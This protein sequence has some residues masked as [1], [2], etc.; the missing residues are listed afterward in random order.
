M[1]ASSNAQIASW[2]HLIGFLCIMAGLMALGFYAQHAAASEHGNQLASHGSAV[3]I[4]LVAG[5]MDWALLY[6][7]WAGVHR[8]GG[9]LATLSGG[10][11]TSVRQLAT[12]LALAVPFFLVWEGV[13]LGVSRLLGH[14]DAKTVDNLLPQTL[15][16][17]FLWIAVSA[18]AGICEEMAF[19]GY[20]QQQ[21]AALGGSVPVAVLGQAL[22]FGVAHSYQGWKQVVVITIL[23]ILYG[24]LAAW[25]RNV[26]IN[27]I[28]H[29]F[30][31]VWEGWL[32]FIF[33]PTLGG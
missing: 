24:T 13:A 32:K 15:P 27:I 17:I 6:Y 25:R 19:R 11:W 29:A 1:Q 4:Y 5:S 2:K 8:R 9:T 21:L 12:D 7:C 31:D 18:T 3:Q 26:R 33:W 10:R 28:A 30:T 16:E 20:L 23:G 22:T 14:S